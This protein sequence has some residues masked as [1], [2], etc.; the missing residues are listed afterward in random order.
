MRVEHNEML[1]QLSFMPSLFPVNCYLVEEEKELTLIDAALPYSDKMILQTA[2]QIGKPITRIVLTHAHEDHVGALDRLKEALPNAEVFI[3]SRDAKILRGD[4]SLEP[5]EPQVKIRG[6]V[7]KKIR[8]TPNQM[9]VDGMQV[10]SLQAVAAPGHTPGS[11]AFFDTRTHALVAG[12]AFQT[13]GGVA[14]AGTLK[15]FFPFPAMATWHKET[16]LESARKLSRLNP[17][18]LA[19]G[20]GRMLKDPAYAIKKAITE[21]EQAIERRGNDEARN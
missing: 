21:A 20:H 4:V 8:T 3:S 12:D 7:P 16:A 14:V 11:M 17:S 19:V 13:R 10:G 9:I 2:K 1:Y 15:S 5:T 18:L 6:G